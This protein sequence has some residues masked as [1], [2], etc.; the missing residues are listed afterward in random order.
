MSFDD[1]TEPKEGD[2]GLREILAEAK[3]EWPALQSALATSDRITNESME[4][5]S[6]MQAGVIVGGIERTDEEASVTGFPA[7]LD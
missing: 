1:R 3:E 6:R 2:M 5:R 7:W 4:P